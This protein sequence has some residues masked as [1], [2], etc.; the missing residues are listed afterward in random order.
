MHV[1]PPLIPADAALYLD[2]DGTLAHIAPRPDD[3]VIPRELPELLIALRERLEGAVAVITGR[4]LETVDALLRPLI[5]AGAGQHGAELRAQGGDILPQVSRLESISALASAA[6]HK[7]PDGG[8]VWVEDKGVAVALHF[9]QA[10]ER[11]T[12]CMGVFES[13]A[14]TDELELVRG[15]MVIEARPRGIHKGLALQTL[16]TQ[17][18]F[19]GRMPVFIGDDVTDEDAFGF[20]AENRGFGVKVGAGETRARYRCADVDAVHHWL[21][22]SLESLT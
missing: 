17:P 1:R 4:T 19:A 20:V 9:R 12:E 18:P 8:D 11:A 15:N 14:N 22:A 10:P 6:R 5:L 2:F 16:M 21:R 13:L 7:F 3:V